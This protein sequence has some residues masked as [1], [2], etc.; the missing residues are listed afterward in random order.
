MDGVTL[1][2]TLSTEDRITDGCGLVNII[3]KDLTMNAVAKPIGSLMTHETVQKV[4]QQQGMTGWAGRVRGQS[5]KASTPLM[6]WIKMPGNNQNGT[7]DIKIPSTAVS[8]AAESYGVTAI[9]NG[10]L[11][12]Q[13]LRTFTSGVRQ[14]LFSIVT[15]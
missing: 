6:L 12:W 3:F 5:M 10:D 14:S 1:N 13:G 2:F 11:S 4:L 8:A 15:P 7:L 9:R